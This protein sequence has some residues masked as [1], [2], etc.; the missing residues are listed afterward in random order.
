MLQHITNEMIAVAGV[1]FV[2][3]IGLTYHA[4]VVNRMIR[5]A[6]AKRANGSTNE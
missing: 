5:D 6:K 3:M 4:V 1:M 2:C